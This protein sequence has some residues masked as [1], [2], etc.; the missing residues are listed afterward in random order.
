MICDTHRCPG[1]YIKSEQELTGNAVEKLKEE[2]QPAGG[3][4]FLVWR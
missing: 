4:K 2:S 3:L 1:S